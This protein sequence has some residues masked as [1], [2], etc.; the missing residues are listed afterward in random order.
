MSKYKHQDRAIMRGDTVVVTRAAQPQ[1]YPYTRTRAANRGKAE[2]VK[3]LYRDWEVIPGWKDIR[4]SQGYLPTN[5]MQERRANYR[6]SPSTLVFKNRFEPGF[7]V[8]ADPYLLA[9]PDPWND[10]L[11][12]TNYWNT[13]TSVTDNMEVIAK[14]QCLSRARDMKVNL[15]VAFGEGRQTV[16]MIAETARTLGKAVAAFR[17][18]RFGKAAKILNIK[19]LEGSAANHW[20]SYQYGWRPLLSDVYGAAE[21]LAQHIK[22]PRPPRFAVR[23][24]SKD[25]S[26]YA[27]PQWE[28][29]TGC[30][31]TGLTHSFSD[32]W[33]QREVAAGL[34]CQCDYTETALAA[35]LGV[36][37][38]DPALLAWELI[39]FSF[40][41]D[42][43][44]QVGNYLESISAL[45]GVTVLDGWVTTSIRFNGVVESSSSWLWPTEGEI[46]R[47]TV[48]WR[49]FARKSWSGQI[50][51]R[52][53]YSL[54]PLGASRIVTTA[55]LWKQRT[56]GNLRM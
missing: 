15:A 26:S 39:P 5:R 32:C 38:T 9:I 50:P 41:F 44:I 20:L 33:L 10:Y 8:K 23:G 18:G 2:D 34:L 17:R 11:G 25:L 37:L 6:Y 48:T 45:Q 30:E 36:G 3:S 24:K 19:K 40:V 46:P 4:A 54:S 53:S 12:K 52:P 1:W 28:S 7:E 21:T 42:W 27:F 49:D 14:Q 22:Q 47:P 51:W 35:Q 43:F 16:R 56:R 31:S 55:S 29:Y 13:D